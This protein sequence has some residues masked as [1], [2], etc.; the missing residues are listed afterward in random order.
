VN[1]PNNK[2]GKIK[3]VSTEKRERKQGKGPMKR[4]R[5]KGVSGI[6]GKGAQ[7]NLRE[8]AIV[9][10]HCDEAEGSLEVTLGCPSSEETFHKIFSW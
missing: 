4:R 7:K 10:E 5:G 3:K 1:G 6:G 9:G 8:T 2:R